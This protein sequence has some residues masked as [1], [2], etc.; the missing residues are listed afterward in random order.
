MLQTCD[1]TSRDNIKK[2]F[3]ELESLGFVALWR[4]M[5]DRVSALH[6]INRDYP[7]AQ[8]YVCYT[9]RDDDKCFDEKGNLKQALI[10]N[11]GGDGA[12][13]C[14]A[15]KDKGLNVLWDGDDTKYIS[16]LP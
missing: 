15:L 12:T 3:L 16:V 14:K 9:K 5:P 11:W 7:E 13:I 6:E 8:N 2:A 1:G 10:L 4:F